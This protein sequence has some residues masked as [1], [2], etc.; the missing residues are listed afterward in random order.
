M[1][2]QLLKICLCTQIHM[3]IEHVFNF[4]IKMNLDLFL[5]DVKNIGE[6]KIV[7]KWHRKAVFL[8]KKTFG[9][10]SMAWYFTSSCVLKYYKHLNKKIKKAK[11]QSDYESRSLLF[12]MPYLY[13]ILHT[14]FPTSGEIYILYFPICRKRNVCT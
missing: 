8:K 9:I 6:N 5:W 12:F 10:S 11:S 1:L 4:W 3:F 2:I 7:K 13:F 14:P